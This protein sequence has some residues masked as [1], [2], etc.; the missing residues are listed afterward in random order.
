MQSDRQAR[1]SERAYLLWLA[2]GRVH[3][4]DLE[5]WRQAEREI[6]EEE[7]R[8]AGA[9]ADRATPRTPAPRRS[10]TAAARKPAAP[11]AKAPRSGARAR[12]K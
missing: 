9:L 7:A 1:V 4:R 10:R 8:L 6:A 5:H 3:G 12:P 11:R 2:E